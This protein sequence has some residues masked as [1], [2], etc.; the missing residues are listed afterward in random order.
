MVDKNMIMAQEKEKIF[1][2]LPDFYNNYSHILNLVY[3]KSQYP[4]YFRENCVI[5]SAYGTFPGC[6]WNGGR[7]QFGGC[8]LDNIKATFKGL[9]EAGISVR[10]TFTNKYIVEEDL[11]DAYCNA[12]LANAVISTSETGVRNGVNANSDIIADYI[13]TNYKDLY[14]INSTTRPVKTI[15]EINKLSEDTLTVP[16]YTINNTDAID[17]LTHPEN[18]ELLCCE[19]C[20]DNCPN[21]KNH[22]D[23]ISKAQMYMPSEGFMCPHGCEHYYYYEL[24]PTRRHHITIDDIETMYRPRGINKFKISGRNDNIINV[25]ERFVNYFAKPEYRDHVRNMLLIGV[26]DKQN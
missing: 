25:I 7:T 16:P 4:G 14:L 26:L 23:T 1:F 19:A 12:V 10:L 18:I 15:E 2:S 6:T 24:V 9:N 3:F 13:K 20:V 8:N 11:H 5:D 17:E 22:Y 21:R